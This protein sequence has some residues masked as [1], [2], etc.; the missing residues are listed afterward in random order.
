MSTRRL[1]TSL[2]AALGC[3]ALAMI[4]PAAVA[5][6]AQTPAKPTSAA[7]KFIPKRMPWGDPD[8]S[9]NFTTKDEA[10]TPFERPDEFA[11]KRIEDITPAELD[12]A[13]TQR[14]REA[15][16]NAPYPGGGSR[17]RGVAIAVPIHWFD[18]LDTVNSRPWFV[19]DPPDGKVPPQLDGAR[20]RAADAAAARR[21]RGTADSYTDRSPGDRCITYSV[22]IQRVVPGLYGNSTHIVQTKDYVAI[23]YEM[24]HE[25]RIIP[26]EGRGAARTHNSST[27]RA[28]W[29]DSIGRWEGDTFVV[30]T[31]N[32]NGKLP[33]RGAVEN[34]H[35]IERFTRV[36]PNKIDWRATAEDSSAWARPWTFAIPWTEDDTQAIFEYACHEGNYGLRNILSAGRSDDKKGIKSSDAV[37]AQDDLKDFEQ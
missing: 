12:K 4:A 26:I 30:D 21:L 25:T 10:N 17:E 2:S 35:T 33:F 34:L 19:I 15:L 31:V 27:L 24:M 29:G 11:G 5:G 23:R 3:A 32:Y 28:Y 37:D 36:A 7:R 9:G 6:Q 16:A 22:P 13:N 1:V 14:R 20:Q 18:S 8:I